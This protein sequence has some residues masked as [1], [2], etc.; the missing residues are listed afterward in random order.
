[1]CTAEVGG[2]HLVL[3]HPEASLPFQSGTIVTVGKDLGNGSIQCGCKASVFIFPGHN[4]GKRV[5]GAPCYGESQLSQ[6]LELRSRWWTLLWAQT[7][8]VHMCQ[9]SYHWILTGFVPSWSVSMRKAL[10]S[11]MVAAS[12]AVDAAFPGG[13]VLAHAF[14]VNKLAA[15]PRYH[16][17]FSFD[18]VTVTPHVIGVSCGRQDYI[19]M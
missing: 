2:T 19:N 6:R 5:S 18:C 8:L 7:A 1:M 4:L 13:G 11:H 10:Q 12:S 16:L 17:A 9:C 14:K 3:R 15:F